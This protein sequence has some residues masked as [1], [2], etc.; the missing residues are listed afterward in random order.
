MFNKLEH[1]QVANIR[2]VGQIWP[3]TLF[4]PA[5]HLHLVAVLTSCLTIKELLH[6]YSPKITFSALKATMRLMW[7]LVKISLT[8]LTESMN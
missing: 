8:L 5:Q 7:P 3:S 4:Y 6:L 2:P 1:K